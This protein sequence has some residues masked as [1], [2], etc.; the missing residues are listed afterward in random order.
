M[1]AGEG[2]L[3]RVTPAILRPCV[4]VTTLGAGRRRR[5]E[6]RDGVSP[7]GSGLA[8]VVP[9]CLLRSVNMTCVDLDLEYGISKMTRLDPSRAT[10]VAR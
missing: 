8:S 6:A 2:E 5:T 1:L 10:I 7:S 9:R 4:F 3:P